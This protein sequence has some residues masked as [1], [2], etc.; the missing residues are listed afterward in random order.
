M[1]DPHSV[2][3]DSCAM[4]KLSIYC[5][6]CNSV[7]KEYGV[8]PSILSS[9]LQPPLTQEC[10]EF[11][12]IKDGYK[13]YKYLYDL[14]QQGDLLLHFSKFAKIELFDIFLD[15]SFDELLADHGISYRLRR[16]KPFRWQV[17]FNYGD[18]VIARYDRIIT[19]LDGIG[20]S[21]NYPE[22][23]PRSSYRLACEI[24]DILSKHIFLDSFDSYL[25]SLALFLMVDDFF[26][27]DREL[28]NILTAF[29]T[30]PEWKSHR[31]ALEA[32]VI[33]VDTDYQEL[34]MVERENDGSIDFD[35]SKFKLPQMLP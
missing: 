8:E 4:A 10:L 25:Y 14:K 18:K 22:A 31:E 19:C 27:Y 34:C 23:D 29:G 30:K 7:R 35:L 24:S 12:A 2:L 15:V 32:E 33:R 9:S 5:E 11:E 20:I 13:C 1:S 26:T 17:N 16:K 28:R 6:C 21:I 3:I